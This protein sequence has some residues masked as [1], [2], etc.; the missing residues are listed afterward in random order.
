VPKAD[1]TRSGN[2]THI[3]VNTTYQDRH[4]M[5]E[6]PGARYSRSDGGWLAPLSWS[7][8]IALRGIFGNA[9]E[10]GEEL[11]TWAWETRE[12]RIAPALAL[13]NSLDFPEELRD[14]P[15]LDAVEA[16]SALKLYPYQRVDVKFLLV[17]ERAI[18]ANPP[19]L[20]KTGVAIRFMQVLQHLDEQPFP[21]VVI[22]PNSLKFAAWL[23]ELRMWAPELKV[24]VIDG[25]AGGRRKQLTAAADVYVINWDA[26]RLHSR[27]APYG[28]VEMTENE[29]TAKE[30]NEMGLRTVLMD[31]AHRLKDPR[32]KQTRAA[33][34]IAHGARFRVDMTGTPV[35]DHVGDIWSLGHA[36]EPTWFPAKTRFMDRYA[37]VSL[38]FFG[39]AEVVG[40]NPHTQD[41]LYRILDPIV[42]RVPKE[43]ALPF[44]PPKLPVQYRHT[45]MTAKQ[46][47][48]YRQ[49][50]DEMVVGLNELLVA[51]NPLAQLTRLMQFAA[52]YAEIDEEGKVR[53]TTP[54]AKV[55]DLMDL[56]GEMGE[57]P[58]V[59]A[60]VS[61]QLIELAAKKL[62]DA[63]ISHGLVTGAQSA[64]ERREAIDAFQGGRTRVILLTL[65]AGAEGITLTRADTMLFMQESFSEVQNLQAQD[66]IYRIGSERH[67]S[68]RIIKQ[69]TPETVEEHKLEVLAEKRGRMEEIVRDEQTLRKL[70][71]VK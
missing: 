70:L 47:T 46:K 33:W 9:L 1:L 49:M 62:T 43:A 7:T 54:S 37:Q 14:F 60:A 42:R 4:L 56:L 8:C 44:L 5:T 39:G 63:K 25:G 57:D 10:L 41:E 67:E 34:A 50:R 68:I 51:P 69:I 6:L 31:E 24:Q 21:A 18:L 40:I 12:K 17:N 45:P 3:F 64:D 48:A 19:G 71:G 38:N 13:R 66:R 22:C 52:A 26:L 2:A 35:A 27:L 55:D 61:R 11:Q 15:E 29:K 32:S 58:L 16:G 59:V 20:G 23:K 65:G 53:L 36:V 28:N 30:L